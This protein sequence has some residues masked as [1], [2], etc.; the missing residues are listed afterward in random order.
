MY[1]TLLRN[2]RV[3]LYMMNIIRSLER[4]RNKK[5]YMNNININKNISLKNY[6]C[7]NVKEIT[8]E[9]ELPSIRGTISK[10]LGKL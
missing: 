5:I 3:K 6:R 10:F 7:N 9:I 4:Y 2:K 1:K 8:V